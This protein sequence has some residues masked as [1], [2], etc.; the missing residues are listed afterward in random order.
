MANLINSSRMLWRNKYIPRAFVRLYSSDQAEKSLTFDFRSDTVTKPCSGMRSA[1]A[2]APVGDDVFGD[3]PS[4]QKLEMYVRDLLQKEAAMFIPSGTMSNLIALG[5]HCERANEIIIGNKSHIF[6]YEGGGASAFMGISY[7]TIPNQND[8]TLSLEDIEANIREDDPHCP[9]TTLICLEDTHNLCGG[10]P[11]PL[12]YASKVAEICKRNNLKLHLDG[13]RLM[14]SAV[15]LETPVAELVSPFDTVSL[16][17][18]KGLGAPVGSV[19]VGSASFIQKARYLRKA[20]GGG[21]RQSG[22]LAAAGLFALQNNIANL[23]QDHINAKRL[24]HGISKIP[25]ITV[26]PE[27]IKTNIIYFELDSMNSEQF[28]SEMNNKGILLGG[29]SSKTVRAVTHHQ[30]NQRGIDLFIKSSREILV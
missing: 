19:L 23:E 7:C 25:G 3:D 16:C 24:A 22:I 9:K 30:I 17:L 12:G 29:Y 2:E 27:S 10:K 1:M 20:L 26:E 6:K 21:M 18:S 8:G 15:A 5:T 11:L 13:A 4:V 28:V 14:N